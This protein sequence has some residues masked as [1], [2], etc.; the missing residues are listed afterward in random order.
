MFLTEQNLSSTRLTI[1][2]VSFVGVDDMI[3]DITDV[4][5]WHVFQFSWIDGRK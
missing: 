1:L 5:Y 4:T 2:V 3:S